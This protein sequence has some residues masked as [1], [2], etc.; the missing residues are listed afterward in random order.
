MI[1]IHLLESQCMD[2]L[3]LLL[4]TFIQ[5]CSNNKPIWAEEEEGVRIPF[6]G[7]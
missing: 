7:N 3:F 4:C 1:F 5:Q 2:T 6:R